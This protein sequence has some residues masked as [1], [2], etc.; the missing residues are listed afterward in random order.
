MRLTNFQKVQAELKKEADELFKPRAPTTAIN[1]ALANIK[2]QSKE[3]REHR[4]FF[5]IIFQDPL[6]GPWTMDLDRAMDMSWQQIIEHYQR[7]TGVVIES[8]P[9]YFLL[10]KNSK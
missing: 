6:G 9:G 1:R 10:R 3:L 7:V 8:Q 2:K 4:R 5:Q